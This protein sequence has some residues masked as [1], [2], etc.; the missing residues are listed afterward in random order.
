VV[1][2]ADG[3]GSRVARWLGV[4]RHG[5]RRRVALVA[6]V[7]G[8]T[9]MDDLGEMHVREGAYL[10]LAPVGGGLTNVAVVAEVAALPAGDAA[11][12][13][14]GLIERFPAVR[15]RMEHAARVSAVRA[16]G[17]FSR[18]TRRATGDGALL[19][20]DAADFYDP[21]TGEGVYAALRGAELA[22]ARVGAALEHGRLTR[23]ALTG[24]DRDR[25]RTFGGKWLLERAI[26]LAV[27]TPRLLDH[28]ARRLARQPRLADL[29][30]GATGDFVP[31]RRILRPAVAARLLW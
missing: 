7:T 20:G 1:I 19:V 28:V 24:Y 29:L 5:G 15:E 8:V 6:H 9:A 31:A 17:P 27:R 22:A 26:G 21:F 4:A 3:L 25:R 18:W 14:R 10:G 16:V 30:V 11:A 13:W 23:R 12:R 2:G